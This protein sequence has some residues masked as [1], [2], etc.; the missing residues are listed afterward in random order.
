MARYIKT[1]KGRRY[2]YEQTY[3]PGSRTPITRYIGPVDAPV[4]K[5][6]LDMRGLAPDILSLAVKLAMGR[7][8]SGSY[9][10]KTVE[11]GRT[12]Q[13][14]DARLREVYRGFGLDFSS[15]LAFQQT[16]ALLTQEQ[17]Q[18]LMHKVL[19]LGR[20]RHASQPKAPSEPL[21]D[22]SHIEAAIARSKADI[23]ARQTA[24][25]AL[26]ATEEASDKDFSVDD[27]IEARQAKF[28]ATQAEVNAARGYDLAPT[29]PPD[30]SADPTPEPDDAP[31][32]SADA[33]GQQDGPDGG[34]AEGSSDGQP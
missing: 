26:Q 30:L 12:K 6:K 24:Q 2:W 3:R 27:E 29:E 1:I 10:T 9:R 28:V 14:H 15:A 20:E 34:A 19:D 4:R 13:M 18:E 32:P 21:H 5:R 25:D 7:E 22:W 23:E 16:R 17:N 11:S 8:R 31:A 33:Q